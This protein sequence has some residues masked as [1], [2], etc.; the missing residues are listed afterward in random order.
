M[1]KMSKNEYIALLNEYLKDN[2]RPVNVGFF[3][4]WGWYAKRMNE[5]SKKMKEEGINV[6]KN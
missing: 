2:P 3:G 1:K 6:D 4:H 5:F